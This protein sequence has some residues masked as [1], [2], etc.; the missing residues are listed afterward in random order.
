[1]KYTTEN[2]FIILKIETGDDIFKAMK[3]LVSSEKITS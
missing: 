2:D 3:D 1:M